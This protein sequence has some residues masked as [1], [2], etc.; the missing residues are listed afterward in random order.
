MC[1]GESENDLAAC[2]VGRAQPCEIT[3]E[4]LL[5]AEKYLREHLDGYA[6]GT[7]LAERRFIASLL[8][9]ALRASQIAF[10]MPSEFPENMRCTS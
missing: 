9:E 1:S 10:R 7:P 5:A 8:S 4:G 2:L 3:N 6:N